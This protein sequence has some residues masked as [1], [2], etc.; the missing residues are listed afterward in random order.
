MAKEELFRIPFLGWLIPKIGAFPVKRG[1]VS[2]ESI[3]TALQYLADEK[4]LGIFP[5]GSRKAT[6]SAKKGAAMLALRSEAV[7]VPAAIIG[8][9]KPFRQML[10]RYGTPI[11]L[12]AFR[13]NNDADAAEKVTALIMQAIENLKNQ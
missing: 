2:K 11:K 9:Y 10:I 8:N 1:G 7:I 3:Q 5:E 6:G 4:M 12:D 13:Q